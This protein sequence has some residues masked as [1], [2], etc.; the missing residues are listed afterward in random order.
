[1]QLESINIDAC[2]TAMGSDYVLVSPPGNRDGVSTVIG[3]DA[4]GLSRWLGGTEAV[5]GRVRLAPE[6]DCAALLDQVRAM[7]NTA[8]VW[9]EQDR[10][11]SRC[12]RDIDGSV[13]LDPNKVDGY[14]GV[15]VLKVQRS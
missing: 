10:G 3:G 12:E 4:S 14:G 1:V 7:S 15:I 8:A 13:H 11:P 6:A 5:N 2:F 9:V